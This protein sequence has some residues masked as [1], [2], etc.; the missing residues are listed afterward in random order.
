MAENLNY[1]AKGNKCYGEDGVVV[2][3]NEDTRVTLP[4]AEIQANCMIYGRLYNWATA[5]NN[6]AS[7]TAVPSGVQGICP[8]GWHIPSDA[9]W[10]VL[11]NYADS[12]TVGTK[13]KAT[14]G[15]KDYPNYGNGTDYYGFLSLPS[16]GGYD[17]GGC[18][19]NSYK[20]F[21]FLGQD[22]IWWTAT[23]QDAN[24][25]HR[26]YAN[27]SNSTVLRFTESKKCYFSIRCVKD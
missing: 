27:Y 10:I 3:N 22:G 14:S 8:T 26:R 24:N 25:A 11:M 6:S 4:D 9:E 15:W 16:G 20:V 1:N 7:S 2:I 17:S 18:G 12:S 5:M 13:L 21:K 23:E 19:A